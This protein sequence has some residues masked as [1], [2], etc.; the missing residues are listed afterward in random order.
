MRVVSLSP[1]ITEIIFALGAGDHLVGVTTFCDYP[2]EAKQITSVGG[3]LDPN[4]EV[5]L[6]L[7]PDVVIVLKTQEQCAVGLREL[8]LKACVVANETL[9]DVYESITT[10]GELLDKQAEAKTLREEMEGGMN[11]VREKVTGLEMRSAA[12]VVEHGRGALQDI[13][14][15]GSNNFMNELMEM[16]GGHNVFADLG[17]G[18]PQVNLEAFIERSPEIIFDA[19]KDVGDPY[20]I[21]KEYSSAKEVKVYFCYDDFIQK[22]GP[23][24][25]QSLEYLARRLHPEAF[26]D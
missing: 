9:D 1:N 11:A 23:R 21:F 8:G 2:P 3:V 26:E 18:Y 20:S 16:A 4:Y 25:V 6:S 7:A 15:V 10:I 12:F 13:Y 22:P 19:T 5:I 24:L 14:V 17:R